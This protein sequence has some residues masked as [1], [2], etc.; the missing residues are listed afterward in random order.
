[1]MQYI[2]SKEKRE[3]SIAWHGDIKEHWKHPNVIDIYTVKGEVELLL[4]NLGLYNSY[5]QNN[6][7]S[8][9]RKQI[10]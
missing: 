7:I 10:R 4:N 9:F 5:S 2:S 3:L 8:L 1:M 6:I